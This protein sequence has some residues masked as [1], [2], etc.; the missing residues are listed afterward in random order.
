MAEGDIDK[1]VVGV[2]THRDS[3]EK[4]QLCPLVP[5]STQTLGLPAIAH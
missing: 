1:N 4:H 5:I 3:R 2:T